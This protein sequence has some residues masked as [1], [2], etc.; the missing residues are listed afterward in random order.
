MTRDVGRLVY[1]TDLD[2]RVADVDDVG[3]LAA[4]VIRERVF[5]SQRRMTSEQVYGEPTRV[6]RSK[7]LQ[8][9]TSTPSNP[10]RAR[11]QRPGPGLEK[12]ATRRRYVSPEAAVVAAQR[13]LAVLD[14]RIAAEA[15]SVTESGP[16]RIEW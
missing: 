7:K 3:E 6:L 5:R 1:S 11:I 12:G 13:A 10:N 15:D 8:W 14:A 16:L 2:D 4:D 9:P